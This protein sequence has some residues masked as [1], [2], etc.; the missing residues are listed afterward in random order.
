MIQSR[1][2]DS[3]LKSLSLTGGMTHGSPHSL[4]CKVG[5]SSAHLIK[6]Q[7]EERK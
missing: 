5:K 4:I 3:A 7:K 6:G 1:D 2:A